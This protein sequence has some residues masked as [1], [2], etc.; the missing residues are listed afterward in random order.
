MKS[1]LFSIAAPLLLAPSAVAAAEIDH[2]VNENGSALIVIMGEITAGDDTKFREL[3]VKFPDA[4]VALDSSGGALAPALEIGRQIR[5]RGYITAVLDGDLCASSCAL[6]WLAGAPRILQGN[7]RLGFHASYRDEGGRFVETGLG[8]AM[9][10]HYLSQLNLSERAVVFATQAS[11]YEINWLNDANRNSSGIDYRSMPAL[12]P[13]GR[14]LPIQDKTQ[15]LPR[16]PA[17]VYVPPAP[18]PPPA[19]LLSVQSKPLPPPRSLAAVLKAELRKPGQADRLA[20]QLG[21]PSNQLPIV[22]E[23]V[24]LLYANDRLIDAMA[25]EL[26]LARGAL[27]SP[28]ANQIGF[29]IGAALI[30]KLMYNGLLRLSDADVSHFVDRIAVVALDATPEECGQIFWPGAGRTNPEFRVV[31]RQG[32]EALRS[33]LALLRKAVFA[34]LAKSPLTVTLTAAQNEAADA[35]YTDSIDALLA[36]LPDANRKRVWATLSNLDAAPIADRC[37]AMI[38]VTSAA[39]RMEGLTGD[40]ERRAFVKLMTE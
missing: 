19:T 25:R 4:M 32:D 1:A 33:Y 26:E 2:D 3:S 40:W 7:A 8:N 22:A 39:A 37:D 27:D 34:E 36:N 12:G 20:S 31:G 18:I 15:K 16:P 21:V 14:A 30:Q 5:L 11:P 24:R 38:I 9:I 29:E 17:P 35:A 28:S 10:G 13:A 23:H 6:I